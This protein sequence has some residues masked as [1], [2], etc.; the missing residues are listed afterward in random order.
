MTPAAKITQNDLN[1]L[2]ERLYV[3]KT[4]YSYSKNIVCLQIAHRHS[5]Q[6]HASQHHPRK[7]RTWT[8]RKPYAGMRS[9]TLGSPASLTLWR[10]ELVKGLLGSH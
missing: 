4:L 5:Q 3:A 2:L 10:H 8:T 9:C 7:R 1:M 6:R